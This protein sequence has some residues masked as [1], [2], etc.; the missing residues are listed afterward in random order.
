M[1][2]EH[3]MLRRIERLEKQNGRLK[4]A[5]LAIV[6]LLLGLATMAQKSA[7]K[8][9]YRALDASSVTL[10]DSRG[11]ARIKLL[12][13][14]IEFYDADGKFAGAVRED[15]TVLSSVR[16]GQLSVFDAQGSDRINLA[17][18]GDRPSI[19]MINSEGRVGAAVGE[20]AIVLFGDANNE[21][22]S[23]TFDRVSIQ[24]ASSATATLGVTETLNTATGKQ[25]KTSAATLTLFGPD[26]KILFRAP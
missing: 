1:A 7:K 11:V 22:N 26:G 14:G 17:L 24:D 3:E 19:Q 23:L 4:A 5:V 12:P 25:R 20:E 15:F 21:Y 16:A 18:K 13:A 10:R 9:T 2:N 6:L 8:V